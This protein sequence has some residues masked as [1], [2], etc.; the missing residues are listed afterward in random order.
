MESKVKMQEG[1]ESTFSK[2][3]M[4]LSSTH[5][6]SGF[7][8]SPLTKVTYTEETPRPYFLRGQPKYSSTPCFPSNANSSV[9]NNTTRDYSVVK[10]L[11]DRLECLVE[12]TEA[13]VLEEDSGFETL[14]SSP[15]VT[16]TP[17][18]P[19][20]QSTSLGALPKRRSPRHL[21]K[22]ADGI[23]RLTRLKVGGRAGATYNVKT[24]EKG[25]KN[26]SSG[27][28]SFPPSQKRVLFKYEP[29]TFNCGQES[30]DIFRHLFE[31]N[32]GHVLDNIFQYCAGRDL[33]SIA[34]VS[35]LCKLSLMTSRQHEERRLSFIAA[36]KLDQ[37]NAGCGG[38]LLRSGVLSPR[39]AMQAITNNR[40]P[41]QG[42]RDRATS[43]S[44]LV[45]PSKIRHHLFL[46]EVSKLSPGD[47]L[48]QCPV[49]TSPSRVS[50]P[51]AVCS[52]HRCNFSFCPDC[53]C[54]EHQGRGCRVTRT[55]SK[56]PKS[57]AVTSKKSKER[58]R[59]L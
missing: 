58:L 28:T 21:A 19:G 9:T 8:I 1:L 40:S 27:N 4:S 26:F 36:R 23:E 25:F 32:L 2:A 6:D 47:R 48:T 52:S 49:C 13:S 53:L 46:D 3:S 51:L 55:G 37:E 54:E 29:R 12:P 5:Q 18:S 17:Q 41:G 44:K 33:C 16:A 59:R 20:P 56:A 34:Q 15:L 10:N 42:K 7:L 38:H 45:S 50:G 22:A 43:C 11:K 31:M 30:F 14:P 57:G 24:E 35:Q 39:R